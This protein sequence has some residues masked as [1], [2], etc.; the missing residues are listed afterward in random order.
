[1]GHNMQVLDLGGG[2]PASS[3]S[4]SQIEILQRTKDQD[5]KVIAEPGRHFSNNT[6][7]LAMRVIGKREKNGKLCY[8]LNDGLYHSMNI[9]LMD[10]FSLEGNQDQFY[11]AKHHLSPKKDVEVSLKE[12]SLFGQTCDGYDVIANKMGLPEMEVGDWIVLG[13]MGSYTV[14]P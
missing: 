8:H 5:Y 10:G 3:L 9:I 14:G 4:E 12:G 13:G 11:S 7:H 1:M 2:Y 6:C